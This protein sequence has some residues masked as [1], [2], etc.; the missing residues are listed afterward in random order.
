[1]TNSTNN[2]SKTK[3]IGT[4]RVIHATCT[5]HGGSRGFTNVV[6]SKRDGAIELDPHFTGGCVIIFDEAAATELF[7]ALGQWLA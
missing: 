5:Q 7:D 4:P 2:A 1:M 6:V 3:P